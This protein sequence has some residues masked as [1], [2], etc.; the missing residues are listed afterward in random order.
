[1]RFY[2]A[3]TLLLLYSSGNG[4]LAHK[5]STN[6]FWLLLRDRLNTKNLLH[7]KHMVLDSYVCALCVEGLEE[8]FKHLFFSCP[9]SDACWTFLGIHWDLSLDFQHMVLMAGLNFNSV[10][11]REIFIIGCRA[12]WCH[13]NDIIFMVSHFRSLHGNQPLW[14][15]CLRFL[16]ELNQVWRLKFCCIWVVCLRVASFSLGVVLCKYFFHIYKNRGR[17]LPCWFPSKKLIWDPTQRSDKTEDDFSFVFC[18]LYI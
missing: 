5:I 10:I 16:C 14:E 2:R 1:M 13:R 8:D 12:I 7:R 17:G 15:S 3:L 6:F 18:W 11:F 9:F 4:N